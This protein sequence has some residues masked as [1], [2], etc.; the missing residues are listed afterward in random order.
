MVK[1]TIK[2]SS[3]LRTF[4]VRRIKCTSVSQIHILGD[5]E[6]ES[7]AWDDINMQLIH[8]IAMNSRSNRK[9]EV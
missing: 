2:L 9:F 3:P 6:T 1:E 8:I 4:Y 5:M 7:H